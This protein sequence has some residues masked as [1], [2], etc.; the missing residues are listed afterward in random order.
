MEFA[1]FP[2]F[3]GN[4]WAGGMEIGILEVVSKTLSVRG[5]SGI[6][7]WSLRSTKDIADDPA[8]LHFCGGCYA[9]AECEW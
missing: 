2:N 8:R 1:H 9:W 5:R 4:M 7:L 6:L 3:L